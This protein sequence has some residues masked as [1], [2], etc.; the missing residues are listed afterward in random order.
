MR[1]HG[2]GRGQVFAGRFSQA[3]DIE[4]HIRYHLA[5]GQD[6]DAD[7]VIDAGNTVAD[8]NTVSH[9]HYGGYGAHQ[10]AGKVFRLHARNPRHIG[11]HGIDHRVF[12]GQ[13]QAVADGRAQVAHIGRHDVAI[14]IVQVAEY[15]LGQRNA[16]LGAALHRLQ[17]LDRIANI[18]T[19]ADKHGRDQ[20]ATIL[21]RIFRTNRHRAHGH[22]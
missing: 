19:D 12:A 15:F 13:A 22:Q 2:F 11:D 16:G 14:G 4:I 5:I 7:A 10:G 1:F 9:R 3:A 20:V 21:F 18:G 8:G 17:A 6:A